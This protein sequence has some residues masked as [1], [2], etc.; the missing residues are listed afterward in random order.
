[1]GDAARLFERVPHVP[2]RRCDLGVGGERHG[3]LGGRP[4]LVRLGDRAGPSIHVPDGVGDASF[5]S[6]PPEV[7]AALL[8]RVGLPGA[9]V[10]D[11]RP[12]AAIGGDAVEFGDEIR[13]VG[14][15]V[16]GL[17]PATER[18]ARNTLVGASMMSNIPAVGC[19]IAAAAPIAIAKEIT[20]P[21]KASNVPFR[22][23][24]LVPLSLCQLAASFAATQ[25]PMN[26]AK[27]VG[28]Q[29][30][31]A[32]A[33]LR[34]VA[35]SHRSSIAKDSEASC[36]SSFIVVRINHIHAPTISQPPKMATAAMAIFQIRAMSNERTQANHSPIIAVD[37]GSRLTTA[38]LLNV[39]LVDE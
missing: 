6:E 11:Q 36:C 22:T 39:G 18:L 35:P 24:S 15:P 28:A 10:D 25:A 13:I 8:G 4:S 26:V 7:I 32:I 29:R 16:D 19:L 3:A 2:A 20:L 12:H 33:T 14:N 34:S 9:L 27:W 17:A 1:M 37:H 5:A 23:P 21:I 30:A 38:D 31:R